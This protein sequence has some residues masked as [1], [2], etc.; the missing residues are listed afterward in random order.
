MLSLSLLS[1]LLLFHQSLKVAAIND[2]S[3]VTVQQDNHFDILIFTQHWPFTTCIDWEDRSRKNSC[4]KIEEISWSVHGLWPTQFGK[5]APGF[6]NSTWKFDY[7]S[8]KDIR[9][10]LDVYWP[11]YEMR[12]HPN[13]LWTHEWEKHGTCAAQLEAMNSEEKYF[14]AG[15]DLSKQIK[16]TEWL[17]EKNIVPG[18]VRYTKAAIYNAVLEKTKFRP[19][20][21]CEYMEGVQFIKEIKICYNKNLTMVHCDN[22]VSTSPLGEPILNSHNSTGTCSDTK[23]FLYP[24]KMNPAYLSNLTSN[25]L[26][27]G[28]IVFGCGLLV[29]MSLM[30]AMFVKQ[31]PG[32]PSYNSL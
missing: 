29:V 32:R 7:A 13:S 9:P 21:D 18:P 30:V 2:G 27:I 5:I 15:V 12:D 10:E 16:L 22:I 31:Q 11:D 6:C 8:V 28:F 14:Q 23:S 4:S 24:A 20:I 17:K 1:V 25:H 3:N 26:T 19:R